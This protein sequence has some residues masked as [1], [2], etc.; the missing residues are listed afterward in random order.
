MRSGPASGV[1]TSCIFSYT[2]TTGIAEVRGVD[3]RR[4]AG[5]SPALWESGRDA[6]SPRTPAGPATNS[7]EDAR[8]DGPDHTSRW[9]LNAGS[10]AIL[11]NALPGGGYRSPV[12]ASPRGKGA[13]D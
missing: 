12:A 6:R 4:T 7:V 8:S 3:S 13:A 2:A 1:A 11:S 5:G 10:A 9:L